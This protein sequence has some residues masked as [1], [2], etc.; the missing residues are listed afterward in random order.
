[1][2]YLNLVS[3]FD[4][5][6]IKLSIF[7]DPADSTSRLK[8]EGY[9][10]ILDTGAD[11]TALTQEFL[12][13]NGYTQ[14]QPSATKKRTATGEVTL[15]TCQINGLTI[16]NQFKVN[17]MKVD[18]LRGWGT[19]TVVGVIGMDILSRLTLILS[20]EHKQFLLTTQT[21]AA[22]ADILEESP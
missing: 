1:M 18:V 19:H 15:S 13:R 5:R 14:Y 7:I 8:I 17:N 21:I 12:A 9:Q 10:L 11:V 22:L 3:K 2:D 20:H 16:A 6:T 4:G